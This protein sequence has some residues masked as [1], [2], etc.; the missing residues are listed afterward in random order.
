MI[1]VITGTLTE[2]VL[3]GGTTGGSMTGSRVVADEKAEYPAVLMIFDD[4]VFPLYVSA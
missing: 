1:F 4:H 3:T 2:E